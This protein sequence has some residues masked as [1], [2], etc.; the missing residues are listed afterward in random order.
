LASLL[1][2]NGLVTAAA[3]SA[4]LPAPEPA[5]VPGMAGNA[6]HEHCGGVMAPDATL[7]AA[8]AA[9]APAGR[10]EPHSPDSCDRCCDPGACHCASLLLQ[11]AA[12]GTGLHIRS[13]HF[14]A[15]TGTDPA[16]PPS[17]SLTPHF[18]PPIR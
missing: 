14:A 4:T 11:F 6:E 8:A 5:M 7:S 18:R 10:G 17:V 3:Q 16:A 13:S 9:A 15:V 1:L 12:P 2:V